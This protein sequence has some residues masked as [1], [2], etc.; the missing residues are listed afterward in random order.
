MH[1]N[2]VEPSS[3]DLVSRLKRRTTLIKHKANGHTYSRVYY[4]ALSEDAI[5]YQGS[6][7]RKKHE[8][9]QI[10]DIDQ[11]RHGFTTI[12]WKRFLKNKKVTEEKEKLAFSILYHNNRHSLDLLAESEEIC[13]QW[14]TGLEC[15]IRRYRSHLRTHHQITDRWLWQAFSRADRDQSG[16]L[17]RREMRRLLHELNVEL[18]EG[19]MDEYFNQ[20]NIRVNNYEQLRNLD[21]EEFLVFYK[22]VSCRPELLRLICQ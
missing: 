10:K 19:Q 5:H 1:L 20:A 8:A 22:Y 7:Y 18:D 9:C 4:L 16:Q 21:K 14:I 17:N 6:R 12:V 2:S 11:I 3:N 15:L 13:Q